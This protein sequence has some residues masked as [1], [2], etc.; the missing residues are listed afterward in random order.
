MGM[1]IPE[2]EAKLHEG[3]L[4]KGKFLVSVHTDNS[5]Q[6]KLAMEIFKRNGAEDVSTKSETAVPKEQRR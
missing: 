6:E 1:G 5:V 2:Y 4:K 3:R